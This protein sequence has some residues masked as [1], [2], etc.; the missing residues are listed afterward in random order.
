MKIVLRCNS[1]VKQIIKNVQNAIR[2]VILQTNI[3]F[4]DYKNPNPH[5]NCNSSRR[6]NAIYHKK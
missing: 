6:V 2:A 3:K 1:F 5:C 4:E